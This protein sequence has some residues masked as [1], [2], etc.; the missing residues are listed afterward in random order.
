MA[1]GISDHRT[2]AD[3]R[4][5]LDAQC[6]VMIDDLSRFVNVESPSLE[7]G[8]LERSAH[9]LADLMTHVLGKPPTI[10]ESDR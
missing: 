10:I 3:V 9:F 4:A 8:C 1:L 2:A 5:A 6:E 7:H